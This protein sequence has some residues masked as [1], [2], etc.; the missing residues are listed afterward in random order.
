M[1]I[2]QAIQKPEPDKG[3]ELE[4]RKMREVV[5]KVR[6]EKSASQQVTTPVYLSE[7]KLGL[8]FPKTEA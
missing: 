7:L 3:R 4:M 6:R 5:R 8:V 2:S 1:Q